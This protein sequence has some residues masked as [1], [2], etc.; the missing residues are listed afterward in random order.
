M[1]SICCSHVPAWDWQGSTTGKHGRGDV[2]PLRAAVAVFGAITGAGLS[3]VR[4]HH[5]VFSGQLLLCGLGIVLGSK[6]SK[7]DSLASWR[8]CEPHDTF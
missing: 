4:W 7:S 8:L 1:T 5:F 2:Q 6:A 3:V